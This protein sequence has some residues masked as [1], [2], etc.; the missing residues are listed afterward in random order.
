MTRKPSPRTLQSHKRAKK[1]AYRQ[2]VLANAVGSVDLDRLTGAAAIAE[3]TPTDFISTLMTVYSQRGDRLAL[4]SHRKKN[5]RLENAYQALLQFRS[6][7]KSSRIRVLE[8]LTIEVENIDRSEPIESRPGRMKTPEP[9]GTILKLMMRYGSETSAQRSM[10][11]RDRALLKIAEAEN[12]EGLDFFKAIPRLRQIQLAKKGTVRGSRVAAP[13]ERANP[14]NKP[15]ELDRTAKAKTPASQVSAK[16]KG[17]K[18]LSGPGVHL[19]AIEVGS[20]G[21][22]RVHGAVPVF[23]AAD[24]FQA[25][26]SKDQLSKSLS[27]CVQVV[28]GPVTGPKRNRGAL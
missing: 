19:A 8:A 9:I 12:V 5:L 2:E 27:D 6:F 17:R 14:I 1:L 13:V 11:S 10:L 15:I 21:A 25:Q 3:A 7:D 18:H 16:I 26:V 20:D 22:W 28:R 4:Q 23:R 24:N